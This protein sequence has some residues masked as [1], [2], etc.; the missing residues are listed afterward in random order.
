MLTF[1]ANVKTSPFGPPLPSLLEE[2]RTFNL[3]RGLPGPV[4]L[5][6]ERA[7]LLALPRSELKMAPAQFGRKPPG[8]GFK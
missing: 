3:P 7:A 5:L 1:H 6:R 2:E 4:G 8:P